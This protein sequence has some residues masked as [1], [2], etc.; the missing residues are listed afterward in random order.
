MARQRRIADLG[1]LWAAALRRECE[2]GDATKLELERRLGCSTE[3]VKEHA[4][5]LG[6]WHPRWGAETRQFIEKKINSKWDPRR[7]GSRE[8]YRT[9]WLRLAK[10]FPNEGRRALGRRDEVTYAFLRTYDAEWLDAPLCRSSRRG[11]DRTMP[12]L[13]PETRGQLI[14]EAAASGLTKDKIC[15]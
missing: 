7:E 14:Q 3:T 6:L 12:M 5:A 4:I 13:D 15:K 2:N 11:A 9:V 10:K 8:R 1:S